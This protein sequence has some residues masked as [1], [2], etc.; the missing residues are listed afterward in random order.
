MDLRTKGPMWMMQQLELPASPRAVAIVPKAVRSS[1]GLSSARHYRKGR[2]DCPV[3]LG[4]S[5]FRKRK[6]CCKNSHKTDPGGCDCCKNLH[7]TD[8]PAPCASN[9]EARLKYLKYPSP[10]SL[11]GLGESEV[12]DP[13]PISGTP[14][15][16]SSKMHHARTHRQKRNQGQRLSEEVGQVLASRH[17]H[18]PY[19]LGVAKT[20]HPVLPSIHMSKS[21]AT[22]KSS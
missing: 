10:H 11:S 3:S 17:M 21:T 15:R 9:P 13:N 5:V 12:H 19:K 7:K 16:H 4:F 20:L 18:R 14:H 2:R 1:R 6:V 22:I 8:P